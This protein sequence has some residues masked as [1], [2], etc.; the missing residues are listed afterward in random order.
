MS[1]PRPGS[2]VSLST[3]ND[4][5]ALTGALCTNAI[6]AGGRLANDPRRNSLRLLPSGPDRVGE[7]L[8]RRQPP[9]VL[10]QAGG[11]REQGRK[12]K[13]PRGSSAPRRPAESMFPP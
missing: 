8:V 11:G 9:K 12:P 10:Y 3:M 13:N 5:L 7:S 2:C 4:L 1:R 6:I